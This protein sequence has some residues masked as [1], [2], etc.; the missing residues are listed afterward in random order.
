MKRGLVELARR[1]ARLLLADANQASLVP[2]TVAETTPFAPRAGQGSGPR[3][4]LL[5]PSINAEH[6]F[7]GIHTAVS[8]YREM[9]S[10]FP[11]SRIILTDSP[12]NDAAVERFGDHV[13]TASDENSAQPRQL[14]PFSDRY[15]RTLPVRDGDCWLATAWWTAYGAQRM[16]KWQAQHYG[17]PG[18]LAY[19]IQ[20][21]EPGFYP[22]SS[23][24][25]IALGTYRPGTD[26]GI[27]NTGLLADY[28]R[29][30]GLDYTQRFVFEPTIN[31]GLREAQRSAMARMDQP[32]ARR[33]VVYG[34]PSTPRNAF[35][36]MCEGLREWGWSDPGAAAW[37]VVAPGELLEDV[38]LGPFK[39]RAL[40]KLA[41]DEYAQLL[42]TSAIGVSLMVSPHPSYPPLEMASFGMGVVTN[43]FANK[44][45]A[46]FA[47][48]VRSMESFSPE[49][50]AQS[51]ATERAEWEARDMRPR[52]AM[53]TGH[54]FL[55]ASNLPDLASAVAAQLKS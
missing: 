38:D 16:A 40:G 50:L 4:N 34:R 21:F 6:Y 39:V 46:S 49:A 13:L 35:A 29:T 11:D 36:L 32:R 2:T 48:N 33:I 47:P 55:V 12:P 15:N 8:F 31:E 24:S 5:V 26:I 22:W 25:A 3:L 20:D 51:L 17:R 41:I 14:V 18:R 44:D 45:L 43:R 53:D 7:G 28:F 27:F 37:E 30:N 23:Q 9:L 52:Y 10:A 1:M 19:L 42:S 54:P